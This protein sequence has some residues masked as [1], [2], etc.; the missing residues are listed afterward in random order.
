[1]DIYIVCLPLVVDEDVLL[2]VLD[3]VVCGLLDDVYRVYLLF[4]VYQMVFV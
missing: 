2:G 4:S 3:D 1:M